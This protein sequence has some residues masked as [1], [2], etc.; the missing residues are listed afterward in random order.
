MGG[1]T[2]DPDY[3]SPRSV[4]MNIGVQRE[5]RPGMVFSADFVRNVQTHYLL[6]VD[7]NHAGDIRY[8]NKAA[9]VQAINTTLS[10]L[11]GRVHRPGNRT[12]P[13]LILLEPEYA[14]YRRDRLLWSTSPAVD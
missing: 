7:E 14:G 10:S 6:G 9:A 12:L 1:L 2:V 3:R 11:R 8:F 5:L 13:K 4:I